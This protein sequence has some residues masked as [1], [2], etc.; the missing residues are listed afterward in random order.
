MYFLEN[1]LYED[2]LE[3]I[4]KE[5]ELRDKTIELMAEY[6]ESKKLLVDKYYYVLTAESIKKYFKNKAKGKEETINNKEW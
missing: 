3:E 1:K 6:I 4:K 5:N 2:L